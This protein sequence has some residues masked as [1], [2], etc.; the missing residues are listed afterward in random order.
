MSWE[1]SERET[2]WK[3]GVACRER[4]RKEGQRATDTRKEKSLLPSCLHNTSDSFPSG[5]DPRGYI[6]SCPC[7]LLDSLLC[8]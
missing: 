2:K 6:R 7:N 1:E 4:G 8:Y 5:S 3:E